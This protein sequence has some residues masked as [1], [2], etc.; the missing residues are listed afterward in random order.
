M[1]A[2]CLSIQNVQVPELAEALA[3]RSA[4]SFAQREGLDSFILG[5]DCLSVVQR[6]HKGFRD[7][8]NYALV[9]EDI[10]CM[11]ASMSS[12]SLIHVSRLQNVAA[13]CLA[14]YCELKPR[15]MCGVV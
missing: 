5:T 15:Y 2:S 10:R 3:I 1:A 9:I 11:L 6:I 8:S 13:H 14:Y 7:C 12:C 4:L